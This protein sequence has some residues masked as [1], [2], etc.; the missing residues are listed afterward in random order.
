MPNVFSDLFGASPVMPIEK[1]MSIALECAET[2]KAFVE[3]ASAGD[4][5]T[6]TELKAGIDRLEED[7][8]ALKKDIRTHVPKSLFMPVPREYL[9]GMLLSQDEI[10]NVARE[11]SGIILIRRLKMPESVADEF[12]QFVEQN[13]NAVRKATVSVKELDELFASGFRGA[14]AK[15]VEGMLNELDRIEEEIEAHLFK[16]QSNLHAVEASLNPIDAVF[17]YQVIART[18]EIGRTADRVGRHLELLLSR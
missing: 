15:L 12:L 17:S 11:V 8:D 7:A 10:A 3:A 13:I 5:N 1:H 2:F 4:W 18:G 16:L 9:V 6:A 14:E